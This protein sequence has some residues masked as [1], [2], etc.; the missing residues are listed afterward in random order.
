MISLIPI[1]LLTIFMLLLSP[2]IIIGYF[3]NRR[4]AIRQEMGG[5]KQ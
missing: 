4:N 2:L 5:N 3:I 1:V